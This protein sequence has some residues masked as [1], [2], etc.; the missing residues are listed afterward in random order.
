MPAPN[1]AEEDAISASILQ[2]LSGTQYACP[3]ITQ[4]TGGSAN[5]VYRGTLSQPL[6][7]PSS[8][9]T[10]IIKH[11]TDFVAINKD[12]PLDVTRCVCPFARYLSY[13]LPNSA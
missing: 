5:F 2:E 12:F 10:V 11:S 13:W 4:L 3:S 8:A 1:Q 6:G 7:A 9:K